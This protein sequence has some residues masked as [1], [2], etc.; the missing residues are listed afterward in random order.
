MVDIPERQAAE[1]AALP[2]FLAALRSLTTVA[3]ES[4]RATAPPNGVFDQTL[5]SLAQVVPVAATAILVADGA[6]ARIVSSNPPIGIPES[7][8]F[9]IG[10]EL[11]AG[12]AGQLV[13]GEGHR[14]GCPVPGLPVGHSWSVWPFRLTGGAPA[15]CVLAYADGGVDDPVSAGV[16][17]ALLDHAALAYDV[18][19][20]AARLD[21]LG[22]DEL[23]GVAT[24]RHALEQGRRLFQ[25][26]QLGVTALSVAVIDV[27]RFRTVNDT[28]G[29]GTG[30]D[31][32]RLVAHRIQARCR[33]ED[34]VG[35]L[36][37]EEYVVFLPGDAATGRA[38]AEAFKDDVAAT[39]LH[40]RT[41]DHPVTVSVGLSEVR[42]SDTALE[43]AIG[44]ADAALY[45]AKRTGRNRVQVGS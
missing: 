39:P 20:Q 16:V 36:G 35:R 37:G 24:R 3:Q 22:T 26:S 25:S 19:W 10:D 38:V 33:P 15:V 21:M 18:V 31:V 7:M 32:I 27:D 40:T 29:H 9:G 44:R 45:E 41:G 5:L 4:V 1:P 13:A 28:F 8:P 6:T 17:S 14:T 2:R 12:F 42:A 11:A 23:S 30:D 43:D 34:I